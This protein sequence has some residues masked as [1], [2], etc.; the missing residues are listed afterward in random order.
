MKAVGLVYLGLRDPPVFGPE[1]RLEELQ[2]AEF[3]TPNALER[4]RLDVFRAS[5][6]LGLDALVG[7]L[8]P[9][10]LVGVL[11]DH[12]TAPGVAGVLAVAVVVDR[13]LDLAVT[14]LGELHDRAELN[15]DAR[16]LR[17]DRRASGKKRERYANGLDAPRSLVAVTAREHR[18]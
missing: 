14:V 8:D 12:V 16:L 1:S 3:G 11:N 4:V 7:P 17:L 6:G 15:H 9:K 10:R 2:D 5:G 13:G 18:R